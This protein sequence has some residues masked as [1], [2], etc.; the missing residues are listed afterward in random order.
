MSASGNLG[1]GSIGNRV[2]VEHHFYLGGRKRLDIRLPLGLLFM[3]CGLLLAGFGLMSHQELYERSLGININLWWGAVM[4]LF[5]GALFVLGHRQQN[6]A[7]S[8]KA[9]AERE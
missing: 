6:Q 5:G 7:Q 8:V 9:A 3:V 1:R 2:G 4:L